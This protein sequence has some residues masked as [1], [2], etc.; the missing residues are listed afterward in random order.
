MVM[1]YKN[2]LTGSILGAILIVILTAFQVVGQT[3]QAELLK[4]SDVVFVGT[5][6]KVGAASFAG[7]PASSRT[8]VV[9]VDA[10]LVKPTVPFAEGS[11]VTV[12]VKDPSLFRKGTQTIF[13]AQGWIIGG[14]VAVREIG[15]EVT[16]EKLKS[17]TISQKQKELLQSFQEAKD[18]ELR[19][20]IQAADVVVVGRVLDVQFSSRKAV[21]APPEPISEHYPNWQEAIIQV[22]S[23]VKGAQANQKIVVR[24]PGSDD[25]AWVGVP[26]FK[27]GQEGTFILKKDKISGATKAIVAGNQVNAYTALNPEDVLPKKEGERIR[28]LMNK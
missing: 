1:T 8:M 6:T 14:G 28:N 16:R 12:E 23:A 25:V 18:S 22:D 24:F 27:K 2:K 11:E 17:G 10:V 4:K 19:K 7:V 20:R 9:R 21:G 26:K 15:H 5:I 13:Y 3:S